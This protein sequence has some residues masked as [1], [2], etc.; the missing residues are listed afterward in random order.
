M[1][2]IVHGAFK[3]NHMSNY[4]SDIRKDIHVLLSNDT[5]TGQLNVHI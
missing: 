4:K 3:S 2:L 5:H 1:G